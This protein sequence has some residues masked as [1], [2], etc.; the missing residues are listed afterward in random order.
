M[1]FTIKSRVLGKD[2]TFYRPGSFYIYTDVENGKAGTL[3]NQICEGGYL[4]GDTIGVW[5]D[6]WKDA[7]RKWFRQYIV[8]LR[9]N[10]VI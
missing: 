10:M 8:Q 6:G 3:G 5:G 7:C 9:R 2:V 1:Q 4:M